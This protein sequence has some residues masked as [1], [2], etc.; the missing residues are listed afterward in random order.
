MKTLLIAALALPLMVRAASTISDTNAYAW[1]GN[2]GWTNCKPD[3]TNGVSV[4]EYICWGYIYAAN[5]GWI[6]VGHGSPA[7]HVQYQNVR[8]LTSA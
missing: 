4:G 3:A 1:G 2:I 8:L 5:V 7:N 6:N